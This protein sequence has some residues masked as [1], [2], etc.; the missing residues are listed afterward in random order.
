MAGDHPQRV[1]IRRAAPPRAH[2]PLRQP[3]RPPAADRGRLALP[4]RATPPQRGSEPSDR[5]WQAQVRLFHR[6]RHLIDQ[7]KRPTV[8]NVAIARELAAFIWA[9]M[10]DQPP[11]E[12]QPTQEEQLAA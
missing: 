5:A 6:Y 9:E 3:A 7:G 11:R 2:H 10:T 8:V 4:P 12:Q 1:L